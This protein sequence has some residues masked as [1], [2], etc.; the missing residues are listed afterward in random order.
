M[1][2]EA[3]TVP[4]L[5][6]PVTIAVD[7]WGIPHIRAENLTDLFFAQ[8]FNAARDRLWQIDLWRKRGLGL[9]AEDF[10]PG[11]LEQDRAARLFLYRGDMAAEWATYAPDAQ[12]I[13][14]AFV[15]GINAYVDLVARE[16]A[17]LPP[18]FVALGTQP[19][20]WKA[21]DVVRIRS[22]ALMRNLLSEVVRARV[23]AGAG[24]EA[25]LLR[26]NLDPPLTVEAPDG[27]DHAS[28]PLAVLDL[29]KLA[30]VPVRFTADRLAATLAEAPRWR[31]VTPL[32]EVVRDAEGQGSNNWVIAGRLT[33]T[34]RPILA[35][36]PHRAH[37]VP[38]LRYIV[39]LT[40]PEFDGIGAGEPSAPG[41]MAG[42]NGIIGFGLTLF[43]GPDGE[44]LYVYETHPDD[45]DLYRY[46]EGWERMRVVEEQA[47]VRGEAAQTLR[48]KFTRH[49]PVLLEEAGAH[50]AYALRTVWSEPGAAAYLVSL[51]SMRRRNH[52]DFAA[53]MTRWVVPAVNQVYADTAGNIAWMAAGYSPIRPNWSGLLPVPGDGRYEWQGFYR[54]GDL[55]HVLNPEQGFVATANEQNVPPDWPLPAAAIGHEWIEPSRARRIAEVFAAT[56]RHSVQTS[57]ALQ[58]DVTS[59]PARRLARLA[60]QLPRD[61]ETVAAACRLLAAF[62]G[63]LHAESAAAALSELWWTKH[64][65][66]AVVAVAVDDA[67][68]RAAIGIG[69]AEAI[70]ARLEAPETFFEH[71]SDDRR[72]ELLRRTLRSAYE[73]CVERMGSDPAT[74]R[75]GRVHQAYF[76][77]ALA[78]SRGA[79]WDIGPMPMGGSESSPM[80][81]AY[82][83]TDYR[84]TLGASFRMVLD[85]GEWDCSRCINTP[86]QSGDPRTPHYGDLAELWAYGQFIPML[87]SRD[88]VDAATEMRI[89]LLSA[90]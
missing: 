33:E 79:E 13:C 82:R 32:G 34:G 48:L 3:L 24:A 15:R 23:M 84:V 76:E 77:H 57:C 43:F 22:H 49:G 72:D 80:N 73:E 4:G 20:K 83:L 50:R 51:S 58:V 41:I 27:L 38:S 85:I 56:L 68:L 69:D 31:K 37:A 36:D 88:A 1:T 70:L 67:E 66:P 59:L 54:A 62:D 9:L 61:E 29:F 10:G 8:G 11:Y 65:R 47:A 12:D 21:E 42:H 28:V 2:D 26:Q 6:A 25:D 44:D 89:T 39:H 86:G 81:A 60:A 30:A 14:E 71:P 64:L 90:R 75:W 52:A 53:D 40:C 5:S 74:W 16:P 17:R 7:R 63:T 35:N 78:G 55:P 18:E 45:P 87:Y 46:G 19:A